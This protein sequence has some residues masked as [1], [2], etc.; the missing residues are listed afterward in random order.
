MLTALVTVARPL[1]LVDEWR[2]PFWAMT[3]EAMRT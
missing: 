3:P 1:E 2:S